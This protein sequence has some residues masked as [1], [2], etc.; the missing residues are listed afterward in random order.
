MTEEMKAELLEARNSVAYDVWHF[1]EEAGY[2]DAAAYI[3]GKFMLARIEDA[4]RP[5]FEELAKML[6]SHD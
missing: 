2:D 6:K 4:L 1:L 3:Q 5:S